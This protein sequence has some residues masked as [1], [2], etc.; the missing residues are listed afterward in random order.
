MAGHSK[1]A[2]IKRKKGANDAK[3]GKLFT[4]LIREITVSAKMGGG[5]LDANPRLRD[6]VGEAKS[7]NMPKDTIDRAIKRGSG[8][9][10]DDA[11]YE[12]LTYEGY[13]PGGVAVL[14]ESLTDNRNRTASEVRA[15]MTKHGGSLGTSGNVSWM[16]KRKGVIV[17]SKQSSGEEKLMD[18][19]LEAGA[20]DIQDEGDVWEIYTDPS[21]FSAVRESLDEGAISIDSASITAVPENRVQIEGEVAEKM[22]KLMDALEDLD[23]VQKVHA[24]FDI[25]EKVLESLSL[26]G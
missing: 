14:I 25:D 13:G 23:D 16:F 6:A 5:D 20:E 4:K 9:G 2:N 12:Q 7:N 17:V 15:A 21:V 11:N 8:T 10:A 26:G 24:N 22:L 1:W 18:L 19:A 3:R